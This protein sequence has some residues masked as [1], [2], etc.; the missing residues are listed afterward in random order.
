MSRSWH[1]LHAYLGKYEPLYCFCI[2]LKFERQNI[3]TIFMLYLFMF[4]TRIKVFWFLEKHA[5]YCFI[6]H[7][8]VLDHIWISGYL[9]RLFSIIIYIWIEISPVSVT[10]FHAHQAMA[11]HFVNEPNGDLFCPVCTDLLTEPF[12]TR[13]GH[14]ICRMCHD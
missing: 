7:A 11:F 8:D 9:Y 10:E 13:C 1:P 2:V 6:M 3:F 5:I 14:Y 4:V 12:L